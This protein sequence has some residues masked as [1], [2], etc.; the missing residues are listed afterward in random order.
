LPFGVIKGDD[1]VP[2]VD[3]NNYPGL[4]KAFDLASQGKTDIEIARALNAEGW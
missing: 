4:A 2:G 1:G 3:P